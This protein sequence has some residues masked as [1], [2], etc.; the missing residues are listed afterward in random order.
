MPNNFASRIRKMRDDRKLSQSELAR[1]AGMQPSAIAHFEAGRRKP[2]FNNVR[3]LTKALKVT[4][5]YLLGTQVTTTAF[6][7]E[8]KL[9]VKDRAFVQNVIDVMIKS[10][11]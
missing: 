10:K 7:G 9:T 2:S 4:A 6:R 5:D 1:E 11:K 3:A 8:Y